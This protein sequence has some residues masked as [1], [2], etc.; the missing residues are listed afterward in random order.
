MTIGSRRH[1]LVSAVASGGIGV[2]THKYMA[3]VDAD[4]KRTA[5]EIVTKALG[6][7]FVSQ[8]RI[9]QSMLKEKGFFE[10]LIR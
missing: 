3:G 2:G 10:K 5:E 7:F 8:G 6:P 9:P 4:G 1:A